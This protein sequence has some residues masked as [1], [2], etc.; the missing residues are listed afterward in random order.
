[1]VNKK[2]F[3]LME[4]VVVM[5][6]IAV[7]SSIA[8]T[9][10]RGALE[11]VPDQLILTENQGTQAASCYSWSSGFSTAVM[12]CENGQYQNTVSITTVNTSW[13]ID[14]SSGCPLR[15]YTILNGSGAA[16]GYNGSVWIQGGVSY[17]DGI[18][19]LT[20]SDNVTKVVLTA[21]Q[22]SNDVVCDKNNLGNYAT[23]NAITNAA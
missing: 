4:L 8:I 17:N 14:S 9:F 22:D 16:R 21:A 10:L 6:I 20:F 18:W 7:L 23:S 12:N 13:R 15:Q 2:A 5:T 3:T 19:D 1:M 11:S